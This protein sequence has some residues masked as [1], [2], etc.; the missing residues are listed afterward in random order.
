MPAYQKISLALLGLLTL[1]GPLAAQYPRFHNTY[2]HQPMYYTPRYLPQGYS[3]YTPQ[4]FQPL[5]AQRLQAVYAQQPFRAF[6]PQNRQP[7]P[8][9]TMTGTGRPPRAPQSTGGGGGGGGRD[10]S[11]GEGP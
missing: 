7:R 3:G 11:D 10:S 2:Y 5:Y 9:A 8:T 4:Q 1:G 6:Y